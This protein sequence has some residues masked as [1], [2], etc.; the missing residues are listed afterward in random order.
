MSSPSSLRSPARPAATHPPLVLVAEDQPAMLES[1]ERWLGAHFTLLL[2]SAITL[3]GLEATLTKRPPH[4]VVLDLYFPEGNALTILPTLKARHPATNFLVYSGTF[5]PQTPYAVIRA[6]AIGFVSK[7]APIPDLIAAVWQASIG[8][9]TLPGEQWGRAPLDVHRLYPKEPLTP[10]QRE[11]LVLLQTGRTY[12]EIA[13]CLG[14]T[15][16]AVEA[17]VA[18]IRKAY[19]IPPGSGRVDYG[20]LALG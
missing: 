12:E 3:A 20:M 7:S 16:K 19:G 17:L 8:R 1:L 9:L 4:V 15:L 14:V 13:E 11:C 10:R 6:G 2:P 18:K 5:E